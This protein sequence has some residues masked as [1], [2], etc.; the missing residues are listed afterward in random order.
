MQIDP[1]MDRLR[2]DVGLAGSMAPAG[3]G[4][5]PGQQPGPLTHSISRKS[6]LLKVPMVSG[7]LTVDIPAM[8]EDK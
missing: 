3:P 1:Y 7:A 5:K 2:T 6:L 8:V 4:P